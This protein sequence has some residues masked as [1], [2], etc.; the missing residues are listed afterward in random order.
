[1]TN[2]IKAPILSRW[3]DKHEHR[4]MFLQ[5]RSVF[6]AVQGD[7]SFKQVEHA[8]FVCNNCP[9]TNGDPNI[10]KSRVKTKDSI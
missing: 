4:W 1:M 9:D 6:E 7:D 2:D 5:T 10:V 8:Y 3:S